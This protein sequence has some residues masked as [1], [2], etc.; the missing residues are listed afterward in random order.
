[1]VSSSY[2]TMMGDIE[3][4]DSHPS[5]NMPQATQH[6]AGEVISG[7]FPQSG[8][9]GAAN[10]VR[11]QGAMRDIA[12]KGSKSVDSNNLKLFPRK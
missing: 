8:L 10:Q 5:R 4:V 2:D 9:G 11:N 12:I 3:D 6:Y 1:M 7:N